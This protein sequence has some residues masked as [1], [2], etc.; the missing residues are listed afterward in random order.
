M[1]D[2]TTHPEALAHLGAILASPADD[3]PR[4]AFA[5]WLVDH[6][7]AVPCREQAVHY[8]GLGGVRKYPKCPKCAGT[9]SLS[10][11]FAE[12]A[13]F[14]RVQCKLAGWDWGPHWTES[15]HQYLKCDCTGC[16]LRR[17]ERELFAVHGDSVCRSVTDLLGEDVLRSCVPIDPDDVPNYRACVLVRRGFVESLSLSWADWIAHHA[18]LV[19]GG[20]GPV[21]PSMQPVTTVKLT[22]M[23]QREDFAA[24]LAGRGCHRALVVAVDREFGN[25]FLW[26]N[27]RALTWLA[28]T[29]WPGIR[30]TLPGEGEG[31]AP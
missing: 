19:W 18:D 15:D 26:D 14:I 9:G 3:T 20:K 31:V 8:K 24:F 2:L 12:R 7:E 21:L 22:T 4:L 17:R 25:D 16:D 13:E 29:Y 1:P 27:A 5:D 6:A 11:G 23:P 30:F 10:N 28:K